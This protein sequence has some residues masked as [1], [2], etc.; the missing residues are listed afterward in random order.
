MLSTPQSYPMEP[1]RKLEFLRSS[2]VVML[3]GREGRNKLQRAI[4]G[5]VST[6]GPQPTLTG[7]DDHNSH[8]LY[9]FSFEAGS[10]YIV[11]AFRN[12]VNQADL[13]LSECWDWRHRPP[14]RGPLDYMYR[15]PSWEEL[16]GLP[17]FRSRNS[18]WGELVVLLG[19]MKLGCLR[20][21]QGYHLLPFSMLPHP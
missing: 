17:G 1:F 6:G 13:E 10:V 12:S 18:P 19:I 5:K 14:H 8:S 16:G 21:G 9:F 2:F 15:Y 20:Q 7:E 3:Q 11:L 4:P